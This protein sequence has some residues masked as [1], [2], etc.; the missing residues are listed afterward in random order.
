MYSD[1]SALKLHGPGRD[2]VDEKF[3]LLHSISGAIEEDRR[4]GISAVK[5]GHR[6]VE[7]GERTL[8]NHIAVPGDPPGRPSKIIEKPDRRVER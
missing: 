7:N 5:T 2:D 6:D 4:D 1:A 3:K 8:K